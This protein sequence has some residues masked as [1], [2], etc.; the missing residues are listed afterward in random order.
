MLWVGIYLHTEG[1]CCDSPLPLLSIVNG[2]SNKYLYTRI[3]ITI[4]MAIITAMEWSEIVWELF[5]W[6]HSPGP[7]DS[8]STEEKKN[9]VHF[10]YLFICRWDKHPLA[11][12]YTTWPN[13]SSSSIN[14]VDCEINSQLIFSLHVL[15]CCVFGRREI[16]TIKIML[17]PFERPPPP[18]LHPPYIVCWHPLLVGCGFESCS[19]FHPHHRSH[20]SIHAAWVGGWGPGLI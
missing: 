8:N 6:K 12:T 5:K 18:T 11:Y 20:P 9:T 4:I 15:S 17:F 3:T 7:T 13:S 1:A 2:N 16:C 14:T 10:I 19:P